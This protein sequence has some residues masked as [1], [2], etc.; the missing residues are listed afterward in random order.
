[1]RG[2]TQKKLDL[3]LNWGPRKTQFPLNLTYGQMDISNYRV[4][5]LLISMLY[6]LCV[7]KGS[8]TGKIF[9]DTKNTVYLV[10]HSSF[11]NLVFGI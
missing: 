6:T 1:M 8:K 2:I 4:A 9:L 7:D 10:L 3:H 5:L 11:W